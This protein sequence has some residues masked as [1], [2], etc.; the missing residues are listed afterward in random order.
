[1]NALNLKTAF[2]KLR[3]EAFRVICGGNEPGDGGDFVA[4]LVFV[5]GPIGTA[6]LI[7][8]VKTAFM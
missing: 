2:A 5:V 4:I 1:M 7:K 8:A 6:V 3:T